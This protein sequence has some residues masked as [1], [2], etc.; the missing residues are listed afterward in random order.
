MFCIA[1]VKFDNGFPTGPTQ[2]MWG[3]LGADLSEINQILVAEVRIKDYGDKINM[4]LAERYGIAEKERWPEIILFGKP[5]K[6]DKKKYMET[7]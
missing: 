6:H 2:Q 4:D 5:N 1:T 7:R 3:E